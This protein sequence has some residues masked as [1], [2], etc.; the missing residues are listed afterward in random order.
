MAQKIST[1]AKLQYQENIK[2]YKSKIDET[3]AKINKYQKEAETRA[4]GSI[5][6]P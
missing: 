2:N 6:Q 5:R 1:E 4:R 3:L